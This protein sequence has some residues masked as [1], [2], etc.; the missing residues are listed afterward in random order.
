MK[1]TKLISL[2]LAVLMLV[3]IIPMGIFSVSAAN[4]TT[5]P[6][7]P[8]TLPNGNIAR[9]AVMAK[10]SDGTTY[11]QSNHSANGVINNGRWEAKSTGN[12][13]WSQAGTFVNDNP[14][15][16]SGLMFYYDLGENVIT[17]D[18]WPGSFEMI[19]VTSAARGSG[20]KARFSCTLNIYS[21]GKKYPSN[22]SEVPYYTNTGDGWKNQTIKANGDYYIGTKESAW[23]YIPFSSFTYLQHGGSISS[24]DNIFGISFAE[25]FEK[26]SGSVGAIEQICIRAK[27]DSS[28]GLTSSVYFGDIYMVYPELEA[29]SKNA[30]TAPLFSDAKLTD[31]N[32]GDDA[33]FS[34]GELT[35]KGDLGNSDSAKP[36]K[37][38]WIG[39]ADGSTV[40]LTNASGIKFYVNSSSLGSEQLLLRVRL[41]TKVA[42][43]ALANDPYNYKF[44][45][46]SLNGETAANGDWFIQLLTR[47]AGS[48]AYV[49][50]EN[51]ELV[52]ACYGNDKNLTDLGAIYA[53]TIALPAG[54]KGYVY[55]PMDSYF[56][57]LGG[58]NNNWP[59]ASFDTAKNLEI[60]KDFYRIAV[61]QT[62]SDDTNAANYEVTY[63]QFEIVYNDTLEIT[64][65]AATLGEDLS[66][67]V[68][69]TASNGATVDETAANYT[70][71]GGEAKAATVTRTTDGYVVVC[72]GILPQDAGK[73]VSITVYGKKD[74]NTI[75][76]SVQ[77]SIKEYC[78]NLID[79][80]SASETAKN[81]AADLLRYAFAAQK[82]VADGSVNVEDYIIDSATESKI[83]A[84]GAKTDFS[85][86]SLTDSSSKST[87]SV[88]GYDMTG[89]A[90]R[91]GN[92]L[93]I[94]LN[95]TAPDG[96][97]AKVT[98]SVGSTE[99]ASESVVDGVA[100]L[101]IGAGVFGKEMTVKLIAGD[102]EVQTLTYKLA[103]YFANALGD[104]LGELELAL[105]QALYDYGVSVSEYVN[106]D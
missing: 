81:L 73:T 79:D 20:G 55:I 46:S 18:T 38:V 33:T 66:L 63:S 51:G 100:V 34:N 6:A 26:Y 9:S 98:V 30:A 53:D 43:S 7:M 76:T 103:D 86:L 14:L 28:K 69:A 92:T 77:T 94:K 4:E 54:Y 45:T 80:S 102:T 48:T 105:V 78:L 58:S 11:P 99:L 44:L 84:L 21:N 67:K 1:K 83:A 64:K 5:A 8:T 65:S 25:F 19:F 71:D 39:N 74:G 50:N 15:G 91:L 16:A 40:D 72:D 59:W 88:V 17:N 13:A 96:A 68:L 29:A 35:I 56:A 89:A 57:C 10:F 41:Q 61:L 23:Y 90:I 47:S 36:E 24:D 70:V 31:N 22:V 62:Y 27:H 49:E 97:D 3:S 106:A 87:A 104:D 37:D 75:S 93:A 12:Y 95:V 32:V 52:K 60:M 85:Q 101:E 2:I 82:F 42:A